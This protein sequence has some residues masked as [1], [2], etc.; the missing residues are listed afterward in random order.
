MSKRI[1]Q[2]TLHDIYEKRRNRE[3][4]TPEQ[5]RMVK[6]EARKIGSNFKTKKDLWG[7]LEL[8]CRQNNI[9]TKKP[10]DP[11]YKPSEIRFYGDKIGVLANNTGNEFIF[12]VDIYPKLQ[13]VAWHEDNMGYLKR[14]YQRNKVKHYDYAHHLVVGK[15][16]KRK[17]HVDHIDRNKRNNLKENLRIVP[18]YLNA[19]NSKKADNNTSGYKGVTFHKGTKKWCARCVVQGKAF[20]LG[21]FD[22][23]RDAAVAYDMAVKFFC[24]EYAL[25]N[26]KLGLIKEEIGPHIS[27]PDF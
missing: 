13:G 26:E 15:P 12:N 21:Y 14:N 20:E 6:E 16:L 3:T 5:F 17:I 10:V 18:A 8:F 7:A 11:R 1:I 23:S 25:T 22:T 24:G 19:A 27:K 9:P 2:Q 4:I